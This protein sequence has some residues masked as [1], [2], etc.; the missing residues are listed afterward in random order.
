MFS[1]AAFLLVSAFGKA[2][3]LAQTPPRGWSSRHPYGNAVDQEKL[4]A[5]VAALNKRREGGGTLRALGYTNLY[6]SAWQT[7]ASARAWES[8]AW[9]DANG[10]P[11]VDVLRLPDVQHFTS[12][13]RAQGVT[14]SWALNSCSPCIETAVHA[15]DVLGDATATLRFG[16]SG[17]SVESC[18]PHG[19]MT[20]WDA[21]LAD[22]ELLL[23]YTR[24]PRY[25]TEP[26]LR[27]P[28]WT[29]SAAP[30]T[31]L[32]NGWILGATVQCPAHVWQFNAAGTVVDWTSA[33]EAMRNVSEAPVK[34]LSPQHPLSYPGCW[35]SPGEMGAGRMASAAEDRS[36]FGLWAITSAPLTLSFDIT[37]SDKTD[38]MWSAFLSSPDAL[39][40]NAAWVGDPGH[41]LTTF[42]AA[43]NPA[44]SRGW[45]WVKRLSVANGA[46]SIAVLVVNILDSP[47]DA[48]VWQLRTLDPNFPGPSSADVQTKRIWPA[49]TGSTVAAEN[50]PIAVPTLSPHDSFFCTISQ[51]SSSANIS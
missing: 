38:A 11:L 12:A 22:E 7:C 33:L 32:P 21:A 17:V 36:V 25:D 34:V 50:V 6:A 27:F 10:N 23:T 30:T 20:A 13:A 43:S 37:D 51:V 2:P 1:A 45:A 3:G 35:A 28:F 31:A 14:P 44:S 29:T 9:H 42:S 24:A 26:N 18:G 41:N 48:Q 16:W 4:L 5:V 8:G 15:G 47:L 49:P 19:N 46:Y 39:A 40:A